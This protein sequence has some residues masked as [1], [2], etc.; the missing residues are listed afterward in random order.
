MSPVRGITFVA[1]TVLHARQGAQLVESSI[2]H[3]VAR[4]A[5][6]VSS[7]IARYSFPAGVSGI[8]QVGV[9]HGDRLRIEGAILC[10]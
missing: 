4:Q 9:C 10:E 6:R 2:D 5:T 7:R 1:A 3:R 8:T